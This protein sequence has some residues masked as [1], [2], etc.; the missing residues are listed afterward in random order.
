MSQMSFE[1]IIVWRALRLI[2]EICHTHA[3]AHARMMLYVTMRTI[4]SV[5][6]QATLSHDDND[7]PPKTVTLQCL[8]CRTSLRPQPAILS[9]IRRNSA[10]VS[11]LRALACSVHIHIHNAY[12][13][14]FILQSHAIDVSWRKPPKATRETTGA[15][16]QLSI[17]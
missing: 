2:S 16:I 15:R 11:R 3:S 9:G 12:M 1:P 17:I 8:H 4:K 14:C 6:I 7:K 5:C 10:P 13:S